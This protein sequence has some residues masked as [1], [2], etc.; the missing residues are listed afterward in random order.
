M[1]GGFSR[2]N[3]PGRRVAWTLGAVAL[4]AV[5]FQGRG[6]AESNGGGQG[7]K[8]AEARKEAREQAKPAKPDATQP[9]AGATQPV[10]RTIGNVQ[11]AIDPKTLQIRPLAPP[12]AKALAEALDRMVT[13]DTEDLTVVPLPNGGFMVNLL[14]TFQDVA[15]A[16]KDKRG[17]VTLHCVN[18]KAQ[19]DAILSGAVT[20]PVAG[21]EGRRNGTKLTPKGLEKE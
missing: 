18:G 11:V 6:W 7:S 16:S 17:R 10:V 1:S 13:R 21:S 20:G 19:A 4:A 3:G 12:D 5:A 8:K 9:A 2:G 14:D 15:M